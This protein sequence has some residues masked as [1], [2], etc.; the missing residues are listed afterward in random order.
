MKP[1]NFLLILIHF[2]VISHHSQGQSLGEIILN[3]KEGTF[4]ASS[5]LELDSLKKTETNGARVYNFESFEI[6]HIEIRKDR[7]ARIYYAKKDIMPPCIF[8]HV[9]SYPTVDKIIQ[10]KS[11]LLL[12]ATL[13]QTHLII[14]E[15]SYWSFF[16]ISEGSLHLMHIEVLRGEGDKIDCI[17][18][19]EAS[20]EYSKLVFDQQIFSPQ[21]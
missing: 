8:S 19:Y 18:I 15:H 20:K 14:E 21:K 10:I 3:D 17:S 12:S 16:K 1:F 2:L 9:P 5:A 4:E 13:G 11:L 7:P 6:N